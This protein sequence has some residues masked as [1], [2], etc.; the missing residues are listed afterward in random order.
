[1]K[2]KTATY[3]TIKTLGDKSPQGL[4]SDIGG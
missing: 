2:T 3:K 1:L 4:Q